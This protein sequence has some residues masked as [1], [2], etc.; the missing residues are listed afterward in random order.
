MTRTY[1]VFIELSRDP[2]VANAWLG[3]HGDTNGEFLNSAYRATGAEEKPMTRYLAFACLAGSLSAQTTLYIHVYDWAK[4]RPAVLDEASNTVGKI[5]SNGGIQ[6][7]WIVEPPDAPEARIVRIVVPSRN[8]GLR[9]AECAARRDIALSIMPDAPPG[10]RPGVLGHANT[11]APA[12]INVTV[13]HSNVDDQ[14]AEHG[15][16]LGSL[17]GHAIAHEIGHVLLRTA[18]HKRHGLMS[19]GWDQNEFHWIRTAIMF[20]ERRDAQRIRFTIEGEGCEQRG[21]I[22]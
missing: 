12:G 4:T 14:A 21:S 16:S 7:R 17:L 11:L 22:D 15:V 6:V 2:Q 5:F 3:K 19:G 18:E 1:P 13:F 10:F 9:A 8:A 20:F